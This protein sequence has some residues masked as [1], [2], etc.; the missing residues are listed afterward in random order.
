VSWDDATEFCAKLTRLDK[1]RRVFHLPTE[2]QFE[3]AARAGTT[4]RYF[5]GNKSGDLP[6][7]AWFEENA[8]S[9]PHEVGTKKPNPW[10]LYDMQGNVYQWCSDRLVDWHVGKDQY[11]AESPLEDPK[12]SDK[13]Q[14]RAARGGSWADTP[15]ACRAASRLTGGGPNPFGLEPL[16]SF[17]DYR[18][19]FRVCIRLDAETA[20]R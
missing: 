13:G 4:T 17:S 5:F 3:Y 9:K 12:G 16:P 18:I 2:A 10:G 20:T 1:Q 15:L 6:V 14:Y 19:G 11:Y 7:Y 8:G